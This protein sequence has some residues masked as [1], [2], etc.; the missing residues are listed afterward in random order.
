MST[1]FVDNIKTVSG[2]D[3]FTDG[4]YRGVIN[5]SATGT[6]AGTTT[7]THSGT[8]TGTISSLATFP[9]GKFIPLKGITHSNG[10]TTASGTDAELLS[11]SVNLTGYTN[12]LLYAWA[13]TAI[14]EN[15]NHSNASVLRIKLNNGSSDKQFAT[16]RQGIGAHTDNITYQTNTTAMISCQGYY[17]IESAYATSCTLKMRGG[18]DGGGQFSWGDQGGYSSFDGETPSAGGTLGFLLFHP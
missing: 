18:M 13:H 6:F 10:S 11:I 12:Y 16:Q 15:S 1:I 4:Q 7:G 17:V 2:T 8:T 3:T 5:A 14:T 9:S